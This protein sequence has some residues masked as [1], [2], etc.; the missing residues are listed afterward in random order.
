MGGGAL[1]CYCYLDASFIFIELPSFGTIACILMKPVLLTRLSQV[2]RPF[3]WLKSLFLPLA[4]HPL[5]LFSLCHSSPIV[6]PFHCRR[7]GEA[8]IGGEEKQA[9]SRVC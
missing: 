6:A 1:D 3:H 9:Y 8:R 7:Q 5:S 4:L 2:S